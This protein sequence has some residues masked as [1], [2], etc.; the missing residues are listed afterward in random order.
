MDINFG[1]YEKTGFIQ[2]MEYLWSLHDEIG[3]P[4]LFR[5]KAISKIK[6]ENNKIKF[7]VAPAFFAED[8]DNKAPTELSVTADLKYTQQVDMYRTGAH[9]M[10]L[11]HQQGEIYFY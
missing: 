1:G 7:N 2:P 4:Y 11:A 3:I 8:R 5:I 9:I 10:P 6:F